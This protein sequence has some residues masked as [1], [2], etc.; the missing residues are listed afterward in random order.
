MLPSTSMLSLKEAVR[1]THRL[2][3]LILTF[4]L[5]ASIKND[6]WVVQR[7]RC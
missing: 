7:L 2:S 6:E 4:V 3:G 5:F 1:V